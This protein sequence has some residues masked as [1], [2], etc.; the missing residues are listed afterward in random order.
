MIL[1]SKSR[2]SYR[3]VVWANAFFTDW[4]F[5]L[6]TEQIRHN[7]TLTKTH[8]ITHKKEEE[9]EEEEEEEKEEEEEEEE[10]R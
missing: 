5:V 1:M 8:S 9:E 4:L 3:V 7:S 10:E 6:I 2:R